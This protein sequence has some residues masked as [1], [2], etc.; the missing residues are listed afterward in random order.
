MIYAKVRDVLAWSDSEH[1]TQGMVNAVAAVFAASWLKGAEHCEVISI[2]G[3]D[4]DGNEL[5]FYVK[6]IVL[7]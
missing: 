7:Q 1:V 4:P 2:G 3:E 5:Q 6:Q